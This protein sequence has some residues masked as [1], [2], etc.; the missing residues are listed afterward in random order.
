MNAKKLARE[1]DRLERAGETLR[2]A[3]YHRK[4]AQKFREGSSPEHLIRANIQDDLATGCYRTSD[5]KGVTE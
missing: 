3:H 2:A 4:A 1:A 5:R